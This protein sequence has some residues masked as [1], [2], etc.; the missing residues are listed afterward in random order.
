M[1]SLWGKYLPYRAIV[2]A[3]TGVN[4][5]I[6]NGALCLWEKPLCHREDLLSQ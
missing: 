1:F 3:H 6:R 5:C 2:C 4:L